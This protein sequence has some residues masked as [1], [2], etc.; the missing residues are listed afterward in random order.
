MHHLLQVQLK[1]IQE[2]LVVEMD[3]R[4]KGAFQPTQEDWELQQRY[5]S[6][7]EENRENIPPFGDMQRLRMGAHF[8]RSNPALLD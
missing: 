6:I 3:E 7:L 1:E 5:I 2:E 4:V 8:L